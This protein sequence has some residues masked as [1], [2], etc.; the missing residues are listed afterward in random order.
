M[1]K[2]SKGRKPKNENPTKS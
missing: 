1:E 2:H